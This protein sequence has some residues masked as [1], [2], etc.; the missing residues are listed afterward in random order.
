MDEILPRGLS[1]EFLNALDE[2]VYFVDRTRKIL[3]W[4]NAAAAITG[5]GPEQVVDH[6]CHENILRHIDESGTPLCQT[7][8]PLVR[9]MDGG[10]QERDRVFLHH[11]TG[12]RLPVA[13]RVV[14][15]RDPDGKIVGALEIFSDQLAQQVAVAEARRWQQDAYMDPLL[16]I[17]NRRATQ[18][19]LETRLSELSHTGRLFG[20]AWADVDHFK[21]VND[22]HGHPVGDRALDVVAKTLA[23]NVR[24]HD[25]VGRWGGDEFLVMLDCIDEDDLLRLVDRLR[26]LVAA[27]TIATKGGEIA[28]SI[29]VGAAIAVRGEPVDELIERVD[30][31]LLS[32]KE[33]GRNRLAGGGD[34]TRELRRRLAQ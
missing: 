16:G 26:V 12:Y 1:A 7:R 25:F 3:F 30:K 17:P 14:P 32:A 15:V 28:V 9:C 18:S 6:R 27:S 29:S 10:E 13:V 34:V 31:L 24:A 20:L 4:N 21:S 11:A 22:N 2:A 19:A 33:Q 23:H 8:C 5:Y